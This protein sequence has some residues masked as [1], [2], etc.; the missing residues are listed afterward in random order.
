MTNMKVVCSCISPASAASSYAMASWLDADM[1][2][3]GGLRALYDPY[4]RMTAKVQQPTKN[5]SG[6]W[7]RRTRISK[8]PGSNTCNQHDEE[9]ARVETRLLRRSLEAGL[10]VEH[11]VLGFPSCFSGSGQHSGGA[12]QEGRATTKGMSSSS[13][14]ATRAA[15]RTPRTARRGPHAA[16]AAGRWTRRRAG[17][18]ALGA[19]SA[20][21]PECTA[22]GCTPRQ[23]AR[24]GGE[25]DP[26]AAG[27]AAVPDRPGGPGRPG[28]RAVQAGLARQAV[29][30]GRG[31]LTAECVICAWASVTNSQATRASR[32]RARPRRHGPDTI[33]PER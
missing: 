4:T 32:S 27:H 13:L 6:S 19:C 1:S 26:H 7:H 25:R 29:T 12:A 17:R 28:T 14:H 33:L 30:G 8:T 22:P 11:L 5:V 20:R 15:D 18:R 31:W 21:L 9:I 23:A 24:V 16:H 10:V 2:M 3:N